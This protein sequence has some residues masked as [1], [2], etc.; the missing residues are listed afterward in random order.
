[1]PGEMVET[2]EGDTMSAAEPHTSLSEESEERKE[3]LN[4]TPDQ[5][6]E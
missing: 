4:D 1:M 3:S 5:S 6:Q 2:H